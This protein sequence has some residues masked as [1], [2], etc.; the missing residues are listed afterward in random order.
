VGLGADGG[1]DEVV[2]RWP[3]GSRTRVERPAAGLLVIPQ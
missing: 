1:A 2:V 3:D